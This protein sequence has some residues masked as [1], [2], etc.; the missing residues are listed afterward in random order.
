MLSIVITPFILFELF[1]VH[2]FLN[3]SFLFRCLSYDKSDK[4][5]DKIEQRKGD[6]RSEKVSS[7]TDENE[8][9]H[10]VEQEDD[11]MKKMRCH[12]R[13]FTVVKYVL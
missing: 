7:L 4:R 1:F 11:V 10:Y 9:Y 8:G 3:S 5:T 13:H 6:E 2:C 12:K